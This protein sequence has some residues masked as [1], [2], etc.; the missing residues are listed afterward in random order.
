MAAKLVAVVT[1]MCRAERRERVVDCADA[2]E[3]RERAKVCG[4]GVSCGGVG[5]EFAMLLERTLKCFR[6]IGQG[7]PPQGHMHRLPSMDTLPL[8]NSHLDRYYSQPLLPPG[9]FSK[10]RDTYSYFESR[11]STRIGSRGA[12]SY[13]LE[14]SDPHP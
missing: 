14:C 1:T 10:Q 6:A 5:D 13:G 4:V 9:P 12:L 7:A 8:L 3:K 11:L 2:R